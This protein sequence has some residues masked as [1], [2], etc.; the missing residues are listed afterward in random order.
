MYLELWQLGT[1]ALASGLWAEWRNLQGSS[2]GYISGVTKLL[3][4]LQV[5]K[6]IHI[7]HLG[8]IRRVSEERNQYSRTS[9][10]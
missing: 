3:T 5:D 1:L 9:G 4:E 8:K 7:D 10:K 2:S 6:I